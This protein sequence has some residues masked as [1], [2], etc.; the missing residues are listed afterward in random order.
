MYV[1]GWYHTP[2][3][4]SSSES[5]AMTDWYGA[6]RDSSPYSRTFLFHKRGKMFISSVLKEMLHRQRST[7]TFCWSYAVKDSVFFFCLERFSLERQTPSMPALP[8]QNPFE[9]IPHCLPLRPP[10]EA[11]A[12]QQALYYL[13]HGHWMSQSQICSSGSWRLE[14]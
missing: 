4:H 12:I 14:R 2:G 5:M 7:V 8:L 13:T 6:I 10:G 11:H 1:I 3:C 9:Q